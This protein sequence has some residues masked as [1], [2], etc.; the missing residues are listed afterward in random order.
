MEVKLKQKEN[1]FW[2]AY[3]WIQKHIQVSSEL[4]IPD[5]MD[6]VKT[7]VWT[8]G[9]ILLKGKEPGVRSM[10]VQGEAL[11]CILLLTENDAPEMLSLRKEFECVFDADQMSADALPQI[12]WFLQGVQ[13][14]MLNPR[15]LAV[16]FEIQS[17]LLC[18]QQE[19]ISVDSSLPEG[20]WKGLHILQKNTKALSLSSVIEKPFAVREQISVSPEQ[21]VPAHLELEQLQIQMLGIDQI[22]SRCILKGECNITLCGISDNGLPASLS[23]RVPFSQLI[24]IGDCTM[25]N[26]VVRIEPNSVYWERIEKAAGLPEIDL[27]IHAVIQLRLYSEQEIVTVA[28]AYNTRMP[29]RME[30]EDSTVLS[31]LEHHICPLHEDLTIAGPDDMSELLASEAKLGL[32]TQNGQESSLSLIVD[33]LY[34]KVDGSLG[35]A[36]R[37]LAFCVKDL[38]TGSIILDQRLMMLRTALEEKTIRISC[39]AEILM[40]TASWKVISAIKVLQLQEDMALSS[41]TPADLCVVRRGGESL[42]ELA[43]EYNSSVDLILTCNDPEDPLYLIPAEQA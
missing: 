29:L 32:L 41:V 39:D 34:R 30:T 24:E 23:Y 11:A 35:C 15:K 38:P 9:S 16:T 31:S 4:V 12:T 42:W 20:E 10:T 13:G 36:R 5:T 40:E 2:K 1:A 28:D 25:D 6:D 27:E 7:I 43:R 22:G 19:T 21:N 37:K 33:L 18:F 3:G 17:S 14:R 8:Q 26:P